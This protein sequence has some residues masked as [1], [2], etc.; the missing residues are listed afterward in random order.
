MKKI[1]I[2]WWKS[3]IAIDFLKRYKTDFDFIKTFNDSNELLLN[4]IFW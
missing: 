1:L 4:I 2:V 3:K